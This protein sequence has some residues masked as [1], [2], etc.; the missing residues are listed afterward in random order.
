MV[1]RTRTKNG[2][3]RLTDAFQV[4][5]THQKAMYLLDKERKVN[6]ICKTNKTTITT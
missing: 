5:K 3:S 4:A 2:V 1:S 6:F